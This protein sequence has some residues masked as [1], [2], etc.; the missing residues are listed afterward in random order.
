MSANL[1]R[2][3]AFPPGVDP[4]ETVRVW[5]FLSLDDYERFYNECVRR[6]IDGRIELR[7]MLIER[8]RKWDE[9]AELRERAA[10]PKGS[11]LIEH[12]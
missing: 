4:F 3:P 2:M 11:P 6:G 1:A 5:F 12:A 9:E 10:S 7:A 8:L